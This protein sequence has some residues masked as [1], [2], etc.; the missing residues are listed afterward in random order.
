MIDAPDAQ[1]CPCCADFL[2]WGLIRCDRQRTVDFMA[3]YGRCFTLSRWTA[4]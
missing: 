3:I 4:L 2:A 1:D